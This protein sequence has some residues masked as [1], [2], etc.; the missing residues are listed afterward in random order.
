MTS[1][2]ALGRSWWSRVCG[3]NA[4]SVGADDQFGIGFAACI[5]QEA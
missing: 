1:H 2:G 5:D 4:E 3:I